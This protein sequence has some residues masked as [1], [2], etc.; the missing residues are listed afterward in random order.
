MEK[1]FN[2]SFKTSHSPHKKQA[3]CNHRAKPSQAETGPRALTC[4]L[5]SPGTSQG[6]TFEFQSYHILTGWGH[7]TDLPVLPPQFLSA[8]AGDPV[9]SPSSL[10]R[11][12]IDLSYCVGS[13]LHRNISSSSLGSIQD[14]QHLEK[15]NLSLLRVHSEQQLKNI[16]WFCFFGC[17]KTV[18]FC[19]AL[20]VL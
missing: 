20:A 12:L 17:F 16:V 3:P 19:V 15:G 1:L 14:S 6:Q 10:G 13:T 11:I 18:F 9:A 4:E 5:E 7:T 8:M 2:Y